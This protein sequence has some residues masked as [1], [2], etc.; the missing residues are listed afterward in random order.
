MPRPAEFPD[1]FPAVADAAVADD[2]VTLAAPHHV[3]DPLPFLTPEMPGVARESSVDNGDKPP[4][5]GGAPPIQ[6]LPRFG[7]LCLE[8]L[9]PLTPLTEVSEPITE[10]LAA[11]LAP[12]GGTLESIHHNICFIRFDQG[13]SVK[14]ALVNALACAQQ[15]ISTPP[16][17]LE[18]LCGSTT[19]RAGVG[20]DTWP[21]R[22][23]ICG[24]NERNTAEP[25]TLVIGEAI[26]DR[27]F[28]SWQGVFQPWQPDAKHPLRYFRWCAPQWRAW[29]NNTVQ[30][31]DASLGQVDVAYGSASG[32]H[33]L[34]AA[35]P[36][37]VPSAED[38]PP[39]VAPADPLVMRNASLPLSMPTATVASVMP[40]S[41]SP[42]SAQSW[43]PERGTAAGPLQSGQV[44]E[45]TSH[46]DGASIVPPVFFTQHP[47]PTP[48]EQAHV[49]HYGTCVDTL[50][51]L[52]QE[53]PHQTGVSGAWL[54]VCSPSGVGKSTLIQQVLLQRLLPNPAEPRLIWLSVTNTTSMAQHPTPLG[55]WLQLFHNALPVSQ[56]GAHRDDVAH[57]IESIL[58]SLFQD[59]LDSE[60]V[61]FFRAFL[62]VDPSPDIHLNTLDTDGNDARYLLQFFAQLSRQQPLVLV[63]DDLHLMD[64]ASSDLLCR[65]VQAGLLEFPITL[66]TTHDVY[67]APTGLLRDSMQRCACQHLDLQ[68]LQQA[69]LPAWFAQG[70]WQGYTD[71]LL[72][73]DWAWVLDKCQ[74]QS[75]WLMES[76]LTLYN[77]GWIQVAETTNQ[78]VFADPQR[79]LSSYPWP[80]VFDQILTEHLDRLDEDSLV[81]LQLASILGERF[82]LRILADLGECQPDRFKQIL[83]DLTAHQ[84]VVTDGQLN[85]QF[86]HGTLWQAVYQLVDPQTRQ[87]IHALA[88]QYVQR[89]P[90]KAMTFAPPWSLYY[91]QCALPQGVRAALAQQDVSRVTAEDTQSLVALLGATHHTAA[92]LAHLGQWWGAWQSLH[93][94]LALAQLLVQTSPDPVVA[95]Q[96]AGHHFALQTQLAI[97]CLDRFPTQSEIMLRP[98]LQHYDTAAMTAAAIETLSFLATASETQGHFR[99]ALAAVDD[100]LGRMHQMGCSPEQAAPLYLAKIDYL[101]RLGQHGLVLDACHGGD[102]TALQTLIQHWQAQIMTPGG[103]PP[104][105]GIL[106]QWLSVHWVKGHALL[107][108]VQP[109]AIATFH[110]ALSRI[111][112]LPGDP[113]QLSDRIQ[114]LGMAHV[115]GL[116]M[117]HVRLG[118]VQE[119]QHLLK[120]LLPRA[121]HHRHSAKWLARWGMVMLMVHLQLGEW[122]AAQQL[123]PL[124]LNQAQQAQDAYVEAWLLVQTGM[125]ALAQYAAAQ[126]AP[127]IPLLTQARV[128]FEQ[129]IGFAQARDL[130]DPLLEAQLGLAQ[131]HILAQQPNEASALLMQTLSVAQHS[132]V[133]HT[134]V[135][136]QCQL[137]RAQ[138][139]LQHGQL[140]A[141]GEQLQSIW[142]MVKA[143]QA[144]P[145]IAQTA[146][147]I[148]Q[149]YRVVAQQSNPQVDPQAVVEA[150]KQARTFVQVAHQQWQQAE[151]TY[152]QQQ[153]QASLL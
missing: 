34:N 24:A 77:A 36:M 30:S 97:L 114:Q 62:A 57:W 119:A 146:E 98:L 122:Q 128:S 56:E 46:R 60:M 51:A 102:D 88:L 93:D 23:T 58:Q 113:H 103:E 82:T 22:Q 73:A 64:A 66:I 27:L 6:S 42:A 19:L 15:V 50:V 96:A 59:N 92:Y 63:V 67:H 99:D 115:M 37:R 1:L 18:A 84:L 11:L 137:L 83:A 138:L 55:A 105:D 70:P 106:E 3:D 26:Y 90:E 150:R 110:E 117:A 69:D 120:H 125:V 80:P 47:Y 141:A 149:L 68:P 48:P 61:G 91:H 65:L 108:Q 112:A 41:L 12:Y 135:A 16:D 2:A 118:S 95:Q 123:A 124:A 144:A 21:Q 17:W 71:A 126:Q 94:A 107:A 148:G 111:Q 28:S 44:V 10:A 151:N 72:E 13:E 153:L 40:P 104:S 33:H 4:A 43:L 79:P 38:A 39:A 101:H 121:E 45:A 49:V 53:T 134:W 152:R 129:A 85:G 127:S 109:Q 14:H 145:L 7:L 52:M 86:R 8:V 132:A 142:P 147:A 133:G 143:S 89:L 75:V 74:G 76:L 54:N 116:A 35:M 31:P 29:Q 9:Q 5:Q 25:F 20:L 136:L 32:V 130:L 81:L 100:A 87:D 78:L 139:A 131:V 140:D